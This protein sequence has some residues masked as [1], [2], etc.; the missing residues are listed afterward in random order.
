MYYPAQST[1]P[2]LT[3]FC[4]MLRVVEYSLYTAL[5]VTSFCRLVCAHCS[6]Q[7]LQHPS[8]DACSIYEWTKTT[9]L[10]LRVRFRCELLPQGDWPYFKWQLFQNRSSSSVAWKHLQ[11]RLP[12]R[13]PLTQHGATLVPPMATWQS[14]TGNAFYRLQYCASS[15]KT[16]NKA[17]SSFLPN[18][19][20]SYSCYKFL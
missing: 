10:S 18:F 3:N 20:M 8:K 13:P 15:S 11:S 6:D 12:S 9:C 2:P 16:R 4:Q 5:F 19:E 17:R 1:F 7:F 14:S